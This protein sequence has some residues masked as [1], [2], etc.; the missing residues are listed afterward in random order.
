MP[1]TCNANQE[2]GLKFWDKPMQNSYFVDC[3]PT[4]CWSDKSSHQRRSLKRG[5][6][7]KGIPEGLMVN[8]GIWCFWILPLGPNLLHCNPGPARKDIQINQIFLHHPVLQSLEKRFV[9]VFH[10]LTSEAWGQPLGWNHMKSTNPTAAS[11]SCILSSTNRMRLCP[12]CVAQSHVSSPVK[13]PSSP[14][15]LT[16]RPLGVYPS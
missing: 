9:N 8:N 7:K 5:S 11:F 14:V 6:V 4:P 13:T 12:M 16:A 3:R 2:L 10:F 1:L 15:L